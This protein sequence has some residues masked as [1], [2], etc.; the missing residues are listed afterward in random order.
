M[1]IHYIYLHRRADDGVPFYV[2]KGKLRQLRGA[3][4][5]ER[6]HEPHRRNG[7]WM[8]TAAKHGIVV[9]ILCHCRTEEDNQSIECMKIAEIGR[10]DQKRGTL[11]N[12]TDGGDGRRGAGR[13]SEERAKLSVAA[14]RKRNDAWVRSI[15]IARKNGGNGGVV[16][17]GDK[18]PA[19]W[20]A[21]IAAAKVGKQNP[22]FGKPDPKRRPL[23]DRATGITYP[24]ITAAAEA[25]G[26]HVQ[27]VHNWLTGHR[28]NPTSL[29]FA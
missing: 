8:H 5:Y 28:R 15:R 17:H 14:S 3:P 1:W 7:H 11:I 22:R 16:K 19:S 6:A 2:G 20:V 9:E 23:I 27:V 21:N 18:L 26:K 25:L 29:E 10:S 24:S 13:T 4:R 12:R